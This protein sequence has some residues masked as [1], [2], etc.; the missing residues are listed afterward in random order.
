MRDYKVWNVAFLA[1]VLQNI[2]CKKDSLWVLW[3]YHTYLQYGSIWQ[4]TTRKDYSTLMKKF[5]SIRDTLVHREGLVI[6][7]AS[8]LEGWCSGEVARQAYDYFRY[9]PQ[10]VARVKTIWMSYIPHKYSFVFCLAL[11]GRLLTRDM[12][13]F[14]QIYPTCGLYGRTVDSIGHLLFRCPTARAIQSIV[15]RQSGI[16]RQ[17]TTLEVAVK[18]L[19]NEAR[20]TTMP[21]RFRR[22]AFAYTVYYIW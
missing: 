19:M 3:V 16:H 22:L 21:G 1:K 7:A 6:Q 18:W 8:R 4:L 9:R 15:R 5:L 13:D 14:L 17:M 20:E 11:K 12:L 10:K 2:H